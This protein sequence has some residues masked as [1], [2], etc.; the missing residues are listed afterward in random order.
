MPISS[1]AMH[2]CHEREI[3]TM[4]IYKRNEESIPRD[5]DAY[6]EAVA[7]QEEIYLGGDRGRTTRDFNLRPGPIL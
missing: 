1:A 4:S 7:S 5:T 6:Y 3:T 2:H